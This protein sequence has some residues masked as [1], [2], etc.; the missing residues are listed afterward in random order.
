MCLSLFGFN[1]ME[2]K[3]LDAAELESPLDIGCEDGM[4]VSVKFPIDRYP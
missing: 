1:F 4:P 3:T 2:G